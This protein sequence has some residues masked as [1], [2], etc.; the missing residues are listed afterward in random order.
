MVGGDQ[1][2]S[3]CFC[4]RSF[5]VFY[6]I[7]FMEFFYFQVNWNSNSF[8]YEN[9]QILCVF[10]WLENGN[11][12]YSWVETWDWEYGICREFL[13]AKR[14][15]G[16]PA[17]SR[18]NTMYVFSCVFNSWCHLMAFNKSLTMVIFLEN[19]NTIH[20]N[21]NILLANLS[22]GWWWVYFDIVEFQTF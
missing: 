9:K 4:A 6:W 1:Q 21:K 22:V 10:E 2:R 5:L 3:A 11:G 17:V 18:Y 20:Q 14:L 16:T 13:F 7:L 8:L 19:W 12:C 15:Q